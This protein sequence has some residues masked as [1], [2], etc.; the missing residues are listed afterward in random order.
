MLRVFSRAALASVLGGCLPPCD[1]APGRT[2]NECLGLGSLQ[3]TS[4]TL[5]TSNNEVADDERA[6][7]MGF[8]LFFDARLSRDGTVRCASCH[9]PEKMFADLRPSS[10]GL[11][12]VD[13]NSPSLYA[14]AWHHWQMWDGRADSLWSQ[15]LLAFENPKEMDFTRLELA[16]RVFDSYRERYEGLFGTMPPLDDLSRFPARGRPGDGAYE[17]MTEPDRAAINRVVANV[18]RALEAY[19]RKLAFGRGRFDAF[20]DGDFRALSSAERKGLDTFLTSACAACHSTWLFSDDAFHAI[21][22]VD[23]PPRARKEALAT[24]RASPFAGPSV[25]MPSPEDEGAYRT[26]TLRN[27][28]RTGPW[29]HDGRFGSL[30]DAITGH[31]HAGA[32]ALSAEDVNSLLAFFGALDAKDPPLPWNGW[33]DR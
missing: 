4:A 22:W 6:A 5:P 31:A 18:G 19:E 7:L 30:A 8:E 24:L 13:R 1:Q 17:A 23:S 2:A 10:V 25:P 20:A 28:L 26:P 21:G 14:A 15:P 9:L 12:Q 3:Q 27:V 11:E 33:P 32:P 16:H 29:G